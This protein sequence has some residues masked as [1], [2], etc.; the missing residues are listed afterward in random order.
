[1]ATYT[2]LALDAASHD[3]V[4]D[5]AGALA[6][7]RDAE[8]V[9]QHAKQR[10]MFYRG[11][12]FLDTSA[13]LPWVQSILVRPFD[14]AVAASYVK[15]ETLGTE[16]ADSILAYDATVDAATRGYLIKRLRVQTEFDIAVTLS[17]EI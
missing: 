16:G 5:A 8:A 11:E 9:G 12:W 3:L 15:S 10:L 1:M 14:A 13:G 7:V 6:L 2:G 4:L 17:T